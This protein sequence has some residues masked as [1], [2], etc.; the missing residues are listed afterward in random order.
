MTWTFERDGRQLPI[1]G[2][3][4]SPTLFLQR[5]RYDQGG[6]YRCV[7]RRGRSNAI[8][9]SAMTLIVSSSFLRGWHL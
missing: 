1:S 9:Y 5:I 7:L 8:A 4:G 6:T 2:Y 3:D